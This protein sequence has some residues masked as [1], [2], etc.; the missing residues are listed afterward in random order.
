VVEKTKKK[1]ET[2]MVIRIRNL[3][4]NKKSEIVIL[5]HFIESTLKVKTVI[6]RL[7]LPSEGMENNRDRIKIN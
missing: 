4:E 7:M 6:R 5:I 1:G 3:L 2:K